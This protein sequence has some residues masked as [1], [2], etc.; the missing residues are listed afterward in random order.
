MHP[1]T[2]ELVEAFPADF[3]EA[4]RIVEEELGSSKAW[5]KR[6]AKDADELRREA[7]DIPAR[8]ALIALGIVVA[9]FGAGITLITVAASTDIFTALQ[10][11][12]LFILLRIAGVSVVR[13]TNNRVRGTHALRL[14]ATEREDLRL[15]IQLA[16]FVEVLESKGVDVPPATAYRALSGF[17]DIQS[18]AAAVAGMKIG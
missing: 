3:S 15:D 10:G 9:Y 18:S 8:S 16:A 2:A 4:G 6:L 14:T 5:H 1:M 12:T 13:W 11:I 7:G 17:R